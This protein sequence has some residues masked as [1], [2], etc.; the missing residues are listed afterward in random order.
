MCRTCRSPL[1]RQEGAGPPRQASLRQAGKLALHRELRLDLGSPFKPCAGDQIAQTMIALR[2]DNEIHHRGASDDFAA[3]GLGD[4]A[5]HRNERL[6]ALLLALGFEQ[7]DATE[8]GINLLRCLLANV[9]GVE[10]DHVGVLDGSRGQIAR[11]AKSLADALRIIDVHLAAER[12]D[13]HLLGCSHQTLLFRTAGCD[14]DAAQASREVGT[15]PRSGG[16]LF[17]PSFQRNA[18]QLEAMSNQREPQLAR[19][20]LLQAL[21]FLVAELDDLAALDIDQMIMVLAGG[22][23]VAA[24]ARAKVMPLEDALGGKQRAYDTRLT[25]KYARSTALARR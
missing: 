12:L 10:D 8:L 1:H 15:R 2:A 11:T 9:A 14:T 16:K 7:T 17:A 24:P 6:P 20:P 19:H 23:L 21:D 22:F 18:E 13:E 25:R 5:C 3:L 4:A